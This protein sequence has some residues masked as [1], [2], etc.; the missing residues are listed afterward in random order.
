M[1]RKTTP[2]HGFAI[3][4][5]LLTVVLIAA[6]VGAV[7]ASTS[8]S[9][10]S[11]ER[12]ENFLQAQMLI[13]D[14][15]KI[16][17]ALNRANASGMPTPEDKNLTQD[18]I[19]N[20]LLQPRFDDYNVLYTQGFNFYTNNTLSDG[21]CDAVSNLAGIDMSSAQD[22]ADDYDLFNDDANFEDA[23]GRT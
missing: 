5:I 20:G 23:Y 15:T 4:M 8:D 12:E 6:V 14:L 3:G 13:Q 1:R 19:D 10:A 9:A 7:A 17:L 21:T 11:G 18:L 16:T 22:I 2:Q